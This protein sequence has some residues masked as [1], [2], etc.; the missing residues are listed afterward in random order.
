MKKA[1]LSIVTATIWISISEFARNA[2]LL[3]DYWVEHYEDLG[4]TFPEEPVNGAVWG[5]WSLCFAIFIY[6]LT[7]KFSLLHTTLL[8]WS[9]GFVC[10]WLVIGNLGVLP[11]GILPIAIPLSGVEVFVAAYSCIRLAPKE[12]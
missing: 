6:V 1:I 8:S 2:F 12:Q 9:V 4:L 7:R 11:F 3:R 5:I 10:M